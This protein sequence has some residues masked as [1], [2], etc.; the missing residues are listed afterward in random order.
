[1]NG[2][3]CYLAARV[4]AITAEYPPLNAHSNITQL[5]DQFWRRRNHTL[6]DG[7]PGNLVMCILTCLFIYMTRTQEVEEVWFCHS[8]RTLH[9]KM[10]ALETH[11]TATEC[12]HGTHIILTSTQFTSVSTEWIMMLN[13]LL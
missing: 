5:S 7:S 11:P 6:T 8:T 1:M 4:S 2:Y 12:I 10:T 9:H 3:G 13:L